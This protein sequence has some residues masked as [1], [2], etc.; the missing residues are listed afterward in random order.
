M[1]KKK[2]SHEANIEAKT[3]Y[4]FP[5]LHINVA[6]AVSND[7]ASIRYHGKRSKAIVDR[8]YSTY[9]MDKFTCVNQAC[10]IN[11]WGSKKIAILIRGYPNNGY[12]ATVYNQRCRSCNR[13]GILTIDVNSYVDRVAYRLRKWA[14]STNLV[15]Q[16]YFSKN[17]PPHRQDLCEGCKRGVCQH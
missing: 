16:Q 15:L 4:T 10:K 12:D 17:G 5:G 9:V 2:K 7:I 14:G 6:M 1:T 8:E 13:L 11:G 3:T